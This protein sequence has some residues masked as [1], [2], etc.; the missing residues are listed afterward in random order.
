VDKQTRLSSL[1]GAPRYRY[2]HQKTTTSHADERREFLCERQR[3]PRG[4]Q[5]APLPTPAAIT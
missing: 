1:C 3:A 5:R 4:F 2:D